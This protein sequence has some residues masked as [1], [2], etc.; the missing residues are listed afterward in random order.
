MGSGCIF[1]EVGASEDDCVKRRIVW[2]DDTKE[3]VDPM[4]EERAEK[5][6]KR[7]DFLKLAGLGVVSAGAGLA[8]A[9]KD[10]EAAVVSA[11]GSGDYRETEHVKTYYDLARF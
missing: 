11:D 8:G 9:S 10:G 1:Q 7:R 6:A 4:K 2:S 3:E 5:A